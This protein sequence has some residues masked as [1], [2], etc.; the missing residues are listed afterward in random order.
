MSNVTALRKDHD[1]A[2]RLHREIKAVEVLKAGLLAVTD[3]EEA[4]R[5]TIEGESNLSSLVQ[6]LLVSM[7]EDVLMADGLK[8]HIANLS[9]RKRR[10]EDRIDT[11]KA[12][13]EQAMAV[14]EIQSI[15]TFVATASFRA[16]PAT[17]VVADEA[18]IPSDYWTQNA[19]SLDKAK[20]LAALKAGAVPG[21]ELSNGGRTIQIR[22]K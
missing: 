10:F 17:V 1:D 8:V 15:E 5:D 13:I 7:D 22:R 3:D 14:A 4:I 18:A 16:T 21:A 20:L 6:A 11:K 19:P 9:E 12:L 2:H